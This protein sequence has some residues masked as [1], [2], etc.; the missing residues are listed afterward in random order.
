MSELELTLEPQDSVVVPGSAAIFNCAAS[1]SIP[2]AT[3]A[4]QWRE[5][6]EFLSS[7][8]DQYR[9]EPHKQ[10]EQSCHPVTRH[11]LLSVCRSKCLFSWFFCWFLCR[12]ELL[13]CVRV[14][15]WIGVSDSCAICV[16]WTKFIKWKH[17]TDVLSCLCVRGSAYS[18]LISVTAVMVIL[19]EQLV[20]LSLLVRIFLF[21]EDY[22][23]SFVSVL[24]HSRLLCWVQPIPVATRPKAWVWGHSLARIVG[25]NPAGAWI[26]VS[27][28]CR[29]LAGRGLCF[30]LITFP[31]ESHRVSWSLDNEEVLAPEGLLL[32]GGGT[33]WDDRTAV[34]L[35]FNVEGKVSRFYFI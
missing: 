34:I 20:P 2:G 24:F 27:C 4:I 21:T 7:I 1:S 31:G 32:H 28:E 26:F 11:W 29:V 10:W 3:P 19:P 18:C 9:W 30:G 6:G 8:G 13:F 33:C 15:R 14:L 25:S 16:M 35:H 22:L 5:D 17:N 23:Y 12:V